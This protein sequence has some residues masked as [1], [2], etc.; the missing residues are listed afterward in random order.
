MI[1]VGQIYQ[2]RQ[3]TVALVTAYNEEEFFVISKDGSSN[4]LPIIF[5]CELE[6]NCKLI[7]EY[8]TWQEA[9]NSKEFK[10]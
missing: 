4:R 7:A 8:P 3:G 10:E 6:T 2:T 5:S 1:K 9:V